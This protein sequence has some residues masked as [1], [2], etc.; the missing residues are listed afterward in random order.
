MRR[1][2]GSRKDIR[3]AIDRICD[4]DAAAY[5]STKIQAFGYNDI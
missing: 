4:G 5:L 3:L 1:G 2:G